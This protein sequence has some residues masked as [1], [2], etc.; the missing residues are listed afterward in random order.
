MEG[1][2]MEKRP[3]Y[4]AAMTARR[5]TTWRVAQGEKERFQIANV[6]ESKI[7]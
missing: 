7:L 6:F 4:V 5:R 2:Q 1:V 3:N